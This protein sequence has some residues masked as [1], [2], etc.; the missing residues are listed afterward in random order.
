MF[1]QRNNPY[2][3]LLRCKNKDWF[4][5]KKY[6]YMEIIYGLDLG[7][8]SIG[9]AVVI[10]DE[11]GKYRIVGMGSRIIPYS[12]TEGDEFGKG[13]GESIN[14]QRTT[15]R[16]ARKTLDR[17]QLRRRALTNLMKENDM[18]S[19]ILLANLSA[20]ELYGLRGKAA[21]EKISLKELGR[22]LLHLNQRRGYKHGSEDETT[23]KKQRD[24]V[25]NINS[26]YAHIKGKMTIGQFFFQELSEHQKN[27][28]YYRI[29]EQI[30]P[31]AAYLEEFDTIW[32]TQ[33]QF[34][35]EELTED[36][37]LK[38]RDEIIYYQRRLKSQKGLVSVCEFEGFPTTIKNGK[39]TKEI[40]V[41]P[42][43]SPRS[44][45]LFQLVKIWENINAITIKRL[46]FD[47][48]K[49]QELDI[50]DFKDKI[51]QQL[52]N[53][54]NLSETELFQIIGIHKRDGY[55][56][57]RNI[58]I[59]GIQGNLTL[60]SIC[61]VLYGYEKL[62]ELTR[63]DLQIQPTTN[64]DKKT[65]EVISINEVSASCE[66]E[67]L[68]QLWHTC[69]SINEKDEKIKALIKRFD[70]PFEY[71]EALARLDF[72]TGNFGNK[73]AKVIRK[74]LPL[75]M[76]GHVYSDSM[77][78]AGYDHSFSETKQERENK[79][80]KDKLSLLP[81]N[82][83]RQPV[84]EKILNQMINVVNSLIKEYGKPDEIR[85]ELARELKQSKEERNDF[86]NAINQRT[87][88]SEKIAE[89][90]F[91]EYGLRGTRKNIE[92]WRLWH[93]VDGRC[94]YCNKQ[95]TV[96]QFLKGIESD[97]EHI[98]PKA[99]FFD[100]SFANK[101]IA[102]IR[103]NSTKSNATA[104]DFMTS[105]G[106]NVLDT[107]LQTITG[108]YKNDRSDKAKT[109]EGVH[110]L[111]GKISKSKFDRLQW[112]REDI[113]KDFIN[114]QLQ[115]TRYISRKAKQILSKVCREV[116]STTGNITEKLRKLWGWEDVL[117]NL[118]LP[119]FRTQNLTEEVSIGSN[120][121]SVIKEIIPGWSKRD[122]H[123]HH[124]IDAL[125]VACTKQG[126]IQRLNT[127]NATQTKDEIYAEIKNKEF[128]ERLTA[129][130]KYFILYKPFTTAEV[131][132]IAAGI[133]VSYKAGKKVATLGKRKIKK[134]GKKIVVQENIIVPRGALSEQSVYGKIKT[135]AKDFK[136]DELIK[137]PVKYLF[138]HPHLIFK[139]KVKAAV[140]KRLNEYNGDGKRALASLKKEPVYLNEEKTAELK[141]GTCFSEEVVIK[142]PLTAI[143]AKD[144]DYI[145]DDKVK[146]LVKERLQQYNNK[147]KEAFK[148]TL[149]YNEEKQIPVLSVRCFTGLKAVEPVKKNDNG[150]DIGFVLTKNNHHIAIYKNQAGEM[151]E[152]PATFWH[153]VERKSFFIKYFT[154]EERDAMQE[155]TIIKKPH[156][157]WDKIL[158]LPDGTFSESFLQKL[159]EQNWELVTSL[160]RNEMFVVGL[161][162]DELNDALKEKDYKLI[163]QCLYRV[164][165]IAESYYNFRLH[166]ETKV[167]DKYNGKKDESLSIS[168]GKA[169]RIQSLPAWIKRNPIKVRVNNIGKI[170]KVG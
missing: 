168:L 73:S 153:S 105:K 42:R 107:Y 91:N 121:H 166:T 47:S 20:M 97:V 157:V 150:N 162:R 104:F 108:L 134:D 62:S 26:R 127:L 160:Q 69:Y 13:V 1:S 6:L 164:Q 143:T 118:A 32:K 165:K 56:A 125:T 80:L 147:E 77:E 72:A 59:K 65:G 93:E 100:D 41:G 76:K 135:A 90:L 35:K 44:S 51:F 8:A 22:L 122:D 120:G 148:E 27:H 133:L 99:F 116:N 18:L 17:Y 112:R 129:L 25:E 155:N 95:I 78:I 46:D 169:I 4:E 132:D 70:L 156:L 137:F 54:N 75:L 113:P 34:Y 131:Q 40:F 158:T 149:W 130:E 85:V 142:Y 28:S 94:L 103:C 126:F 49:H 79:E 38:V 10:I 36:L 119:K 151:V 86:F 16:T 110:C 39:T 81:K 67:P 29:K 50:T 14:Q 9:W 123:R 170:V 43:V 58:R 139:K 55:Y 111:T 52:N 154:R 23:D 66:K 64:I 30:F 163:N 114:R 11:S 5:L 7:V 31:R 101:T 24:W 19:D 88:Q 37:R 159:P 63:F 161:N 167:D 2:C 87:K 106:E 74:I 84:V 96:D 152:L 98:I 92:K 115:E 146:E 145:I 53:K 138:E 3:D 144:V 117:P 33:Q 141:F 102:H 89:R 83:L 45:P 128:S 12:D 136:K 61:K 140:E 57:D 82:S 15:D 60:A 109:E 21:I 48:K 124:A 71:A 68:Y